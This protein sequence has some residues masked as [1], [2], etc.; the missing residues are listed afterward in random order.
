MKYIVILALLLTACAQQHSV[1][2][3]FALT[4][5]AAYFGQDSLRAIELAFEDTE[6]ILT[7]ED[8]KAEAKGTLS[9]VQK[10][11]SVDDVQVIIGPTFGDSF[12]NIVGP[13]GEEHQVVQITPS[14][15]LEI[16]E[17]TV[18]YS[19]YFSTWYP[20]VPEIE[21]Q[22]QFLQENGY[23]KVVVIHDQDAFNTKFSE[24]YME[25]MGK[26]GIT[27]Q[28]RFEIPLDTRDFRT[29]LTKAKQHDPEILLIMIY[30]VGQLGNIVRNT[31]EIGMDVKIMSTA[32]TQV[33]DLI[34][35]YRDFVEDRIYYTYPDT[36]NERYGEFVQKFEKKY[37]RTP[38]AA[39]APGA[40]DAARAVIATLD[41]GARTGT[42]IRDSLYELEI[43]GTIVET[44]SFNEK[45]QI[46]E[47]PFVIKTVRDG[48]F[49][50][51]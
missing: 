12:G 22:L 19:Y 13:L 32:S 26:N 23:T 3:A 33:D 5:D 4:G 29:V 21:R 39:S 37:G 15:A 44:L 16:P 50:I 28:E 34:E 27:I 9:A 1:G 51:V 6:Y 46:K 38:V 18:D 47:A 31:Q 35:L 45:G 48:Q 43:D 41:S 7:V 30:D 36:S 14:G 2:V 10:L 49:V 42:E 40:Y 24:N 8:T 17:D 11:I 20:Q 25:V